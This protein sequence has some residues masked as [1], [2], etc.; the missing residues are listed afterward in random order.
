MSIADRTKERRDALGLTQEDLAKAVGISQTAIHKLEEGRTKK[1]RHII[2]LARA[3]RCQPEWLLTG[4]DE[5]T[6]SPAVE[7]ITLGPPIQGFYPLISW[8]QAAT[9]VEEKEHNIQ[10][11]MH[12][13]CPIKCSDQTFVL[14][15]PGISMS[16]ILNEG[17]Y[18]F[19]DP[20]IKPKHGSNVIV[21]LNGSKQATIKQV[22][23]E[24]GQEYL[25][26][27]NPQWP[28]Q[29]V[30]LDEN[31]TVIGVVIFAGRPFG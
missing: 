28:E 23:V 8:E 3:L 17:E 26:P 9:W 22:V 2:E 24:A 14:V 15:V 7:G 16:P 10:D 31:C 6:R 18:I 27:A 13:P 30:P 20:D 5:P 25:K 19:I 1:P 12:Y 21:R 4:K 29:I 11:A